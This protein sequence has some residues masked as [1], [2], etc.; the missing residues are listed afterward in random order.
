M[1]GSLGRIENLVI[2]LQ[3]H[4]QNTGLYLMK[5]I[6]RYNQYFTISN[7]SSYNHAYLVNVVWLHWFL[8]CNTHNH[9]D[10]L[11]LAS[12]WVLNINSSHSHNVATYDLFDDNNRLQVLL[13]CIWYWVFLYVVHKNSLHKNVQN[14]MFFRFSWCIK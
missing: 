4:L 14:P 12:Y 11:R 8:A 10:W 7:Y 1:D 2:H 3:C 9:V 6:I 5:F 13:N